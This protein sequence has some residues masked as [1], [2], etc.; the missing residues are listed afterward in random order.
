M[1]HSEK[2]YKSIYRQPDVNKDILM[3]PKMLNY[4]VGNS[5]KNNALISLRLTSIATNGDLES[6]VPEQENRADS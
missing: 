1:D 6:V 5:E 4:V 3:M 2:I